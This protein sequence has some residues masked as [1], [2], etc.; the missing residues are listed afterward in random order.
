MNNLSVDRRNRIFIWASLGISLGIAA[1]LSPLASQHP[2]GLDRVAQDLE[3][4]KKAISHPVTHKLP[5]YAVFEE[6]AVRGVPERLATPLAG[7]IG[8]L[9]TFGLAWGVGKLTVRRSHN[10]QAEDGKL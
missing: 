2:D 7:A 9:A 4:E 1:L 6:Y 5:F 3:F 10:S 8:T